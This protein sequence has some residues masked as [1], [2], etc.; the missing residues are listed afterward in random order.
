MSEN[1][2]EKPGIFKFNVAGHPDYAKTQSPSLF[3]IDNIPL[4]KW[5]KVL[6]GVMDFQNIVM[7]GRF[8][9]LLMF[10]L[11]VTVPQMDRHVRLQS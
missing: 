9:D 4:H 2:L 6:F 3:K 11:M 7:P 5:Q 10:T 1:H 8:C